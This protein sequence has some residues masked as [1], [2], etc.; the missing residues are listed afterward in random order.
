MQ[1]FRGVAA[2]AFAL[3][4]AGPA[5]A[6]DAAPPPPKTIHDLDRQITALLAKG[7]VP[8]ASVVLIE[9][10]AVTFAKGYG[11]ADVA[12]RIPATPDTPFR[13]GSISKSF[14]SIAVMTLVEQHRLAL[15]A[16]VAA[17]LPEVH[18]VNPWEKTDPVRLVNLLEHTTGWPDISTRVLSKD[19]PSWTVAQGVQF[20]SAEFVSRWKPGYFTVYNNAGPAVAGL[21]IEKAAGESFDAYLRDTVLRPMGMATADFGLP[22]ALAARIARSYAPDGSITP[23]QYIVLKPAGSLTVSARE[24]A[25]LARLYIGRGTLDGRRILTPASVARIERGESNLGARYGF[26]NAYALGNA[27]FPDPGIAFRGHNGSIDS[28]TAVMGYTLRNRSGYVV[29]AN[30]GEGA[31]FGTPIS[32][33]IETYLT[34]GLE[35]APPPTVKLSDAQLQAYAGFYRNITPPNAMLRPYTEILGITRVQ[36]APGRLIVS[37]NDWFAISAHSFRRF[38][39]E[40][41]SLAFVADGGKVYKIGAFNAAVKESFALI[42]AIWAVLALIGLGAIGGVVMLVPWIVGQVRGRLAARGGLLMR[43]LPLLSVAA[44]VATFALPFGVINDSGASAVHQLAEVGPYSLTVLVCSVL[45]PLLALL[46]L[47]LAVR[48]AAAPLAIRAYVGLASLGLVAAGVYA[49]SIGW[50]AVRSWTM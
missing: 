9:N 43:L 8:G 25:Q 15:D 17:L 4:C 2:A 22:P 27:P 6:D 21:A 45:Y 16:P 14:T 19:E 30:G 13:A 33:A 47:V 50:F 5:A 7:N 10:G 40:A 11:L 38:D 28:F 39:R 35:M 37:G 34:R 24:L 48:N 1:V 31:D 12:R 42:L 41:A 26:A 20:T 23:Y 44:L 46:G 29:M 36:A 32:Q 49:A 18:F 3:F